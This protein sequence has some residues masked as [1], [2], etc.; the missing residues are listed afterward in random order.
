VIIAHLASDKSVEKVS[1]EADC[2]LTP[3]LFS[4][5]CYKYNTIMVIN[6]AVV[7]GVLV[8]VWNNSFLT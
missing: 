6:K 7:I 5:T 1:W 3:A 8:S 2:E 4:L